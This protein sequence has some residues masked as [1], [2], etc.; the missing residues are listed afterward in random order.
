M[1]GSLLYE[2]KAKKVY[3]VTDQ[4]ERLILSYKNDATA[5]NGKKKDQFEGKGRLNNLITSRVFDY[6]KL[7]H[8][9]SHFIEALN[10]TEQLVEK[11]TIIPLEV[12]VRNV[13]AGS[14]TRRLGIEEKTTFTPPIV[15]LFYKKD[16]LDDPIIN[17]VHAYHLT[18]VSEQ[19]L[20]RIKEMALTINEHLIELFKQAGLQLVDFKLEFG[21]LKD[22]TIVLADEI[23]PDTCRLW[24]LES[25]QKLDK[26][27]FREGIGDLIETY[28]LILQ[29]LEENTCAK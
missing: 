24:D 3:H 18:D 17:D 9:P 8:I 28:E 12:V 19:E 23:S 6:L 7:H 15:E 16:E 25:G 10:D 4:P 13:A 21:R 2:G 20:T 5:F 27:V 1:K 26:D 14:I 29:R 22:G 11:T